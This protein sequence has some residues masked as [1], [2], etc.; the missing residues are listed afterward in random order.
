MTI[1]GATGT[2]IQSSQVGGGV[3]INNFA[4]T[5]VGTTNT[6]ITLKG[7]NGGTDKRLLKLEGDVT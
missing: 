5:L 4:S 7:G 6:V 2:N 1:S 3:N